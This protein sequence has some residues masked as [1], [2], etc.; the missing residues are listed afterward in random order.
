MPQCNSM[1]CA[2]SYGDL[3]FGLIYGILFQFQANPFAKIEI[4]ENNYNINN[5]AYSIVVTFCD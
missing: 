1:P 3:I 4:H 5:L 2:I